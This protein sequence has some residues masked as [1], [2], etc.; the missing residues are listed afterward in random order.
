MKEEVKNEIKNEV[1]N[2]KNA[3]YVLKVNRQTHRIEIMGER[4][5]P[6][7]PFEFSKDSNSTR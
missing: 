7:I 5:P 3:K 4:R 2:E 1:K 6:N